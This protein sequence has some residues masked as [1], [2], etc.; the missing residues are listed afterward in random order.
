MSSE[1]CRGQVSSEVCRGQVSSEVCRRQVS[2]EVFFEVRLL[3]RPAVFGGG[4]GSALAAK[5]IRAACWG[6]R[7]LPLGAPLSHGC[8]SPRKDVF[9]G[10]PRDAAGRALSNDCATAHSRVRKQSTLVSTLPHRVRKGLLYTR[11]RRVHILLE[12]TA[13]AVR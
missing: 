12:L 2:S 13:D 6:T 8:A 10:V 11:G 7:C 9:G 4:G 5:V 3:R 1:V